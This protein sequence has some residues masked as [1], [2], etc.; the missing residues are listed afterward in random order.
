M[1]FLQ[2]EAMMKNATDECVQIFLPQP[3]SWLVS[4]TTYEFLMR[5]SQANPN[6]SADSGAERD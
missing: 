4:Q 6:V 5:E 2:L 1:G 3:D